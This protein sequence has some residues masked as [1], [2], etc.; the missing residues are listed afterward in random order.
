MPIKVSRTAHVLRIG[1]SWRLE[2]D[3]WPKITSKVG[4]AADQNPW[5]DIGLTPVLYLP[6]SVFATAPAQGCHR[7]G[8]ANVGVMA[9]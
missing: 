3:G 5:H 7:K 1:A 8:Q 2:L 6:T 4:Q 9:A